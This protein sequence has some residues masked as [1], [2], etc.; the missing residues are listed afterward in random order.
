MN[1]KLLIVVISVMLSAVPAAAQ[2]YLGGRLGYGMSFGSFDT[3]ES[4][5]LKMGNVWNRWSGGVAW[6]YYSSDLHNGKVEKYLA[7]ISMEIEF[8][9]KGYEFYQKNISGEFT[10]Q[11]YRRTFSSIHVPLIWQPHINMFGNRFR[12]FLNAGVWFSYNLPNSKFEYLDAGKVTAT[13]DYKNILIRDNPFGYGL[14]GGLGFDISFERCTISVDARFYYS[15][16]DVLR[17]RTKYP[18]SVKPSTDP[19]YDP[20][21]VIRNPL[22]SPVNNI[23]VSVGVFYRLTDGP[24]NPRQSK[25]AVR[26]AEERMEAQLLEALSQKAEENGNDQTTESSEADTEGH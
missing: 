1:K 18:N 24:Y 6:K 22:R 16:G 2:H 20:T 25:R 26:R 21:F 11:S 13:Y 7:G 9:Q 8:L 14:C 19:D 4:T 3:G 12:I 15:F 17:N 10:D 23:N 5:K